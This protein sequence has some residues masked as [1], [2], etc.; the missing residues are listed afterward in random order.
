LP[1]KIDNASAWHTERRKTKG[2]RNLAF[3]VVLAGRR[4][5]WSQLKNTA[6]SLAVVFAYSCSVPP[7]LSST[8]YSR[9]NLQMLETKHSCLNHVFIK[10]EINHNVKLITGIHSSKINLFYMV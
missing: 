2:K 3:I 6:K 4:R 9:E 8:R 10:D 1:A 7:G 5:D